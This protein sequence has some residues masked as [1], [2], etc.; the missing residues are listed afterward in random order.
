MHCAITTAWSAACITVMDAASL[1]GMDITAIGGTGSEP[2][3]TLA[4]VRFHAT[5]WEWAAYT[6]LE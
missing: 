2:L 4:A 3:V 1:A 5:Q 6:G